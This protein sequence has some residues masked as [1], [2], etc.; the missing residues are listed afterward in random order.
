MQVHATINEQTLETLCFCRHQESLMSTWLPIPDMFQ[1]RPQNKVGVSSHEEHW[2][3]FKSSPLQFALVHVIGCGNIG[4]GRG[5]VHG[6][7]SNTTGQDGSG[8]RY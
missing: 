2:R 8:T 4:S 1:S 7:C 6:Q 3:L 5:R